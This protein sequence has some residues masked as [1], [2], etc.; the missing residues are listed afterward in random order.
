MDWT[1]DCIGNCGDLENHDDETDTY[2]MDQYQFDFW[3]N[4]L[5][6]QQ[7]ADEAKKECRDNIECNFD[8]EIFD[9]EIENAINQVNEMC[10]QPRAIMGVVNGYNK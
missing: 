6:S 9:S 7:A 4:Y 3:K 10:D 5:E 1:L 8:R 2:E